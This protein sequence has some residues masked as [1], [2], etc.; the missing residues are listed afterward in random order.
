MIFPFNHREGLIVVRTQEFGPIGDSVARLAL[1][2]RA[3]RTM[4]GT[5]M[6][7]WVGYDPAGESGRIR[8]TTASGI[9]FAPTFPVDLLEAFG[10][11]RVNFPV[12]GHTLPPSASVDGLLGLDFFRGHRLSL[13]FVEGEIEVE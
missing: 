8:V 10:Q 9:E 5:A 1:D 12:I 6:L 7:V 11:R 13:D 3:I 2:T 4:I